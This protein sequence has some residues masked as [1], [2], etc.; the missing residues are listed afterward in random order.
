MIRIDQPAGLVDAGIVPVVI[1]GRRLASEEPSNGVAEILEFFSDEELAVDPN[2]RRAVTTAKTRHA[3]YGHPRRL[4]RLDLPIQFCLEFL[5][6]RDQPGSA[7]EMAGHVRADLD[8][9][10]R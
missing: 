9:N 1:R 6:L 7:P 10:V 4:V 8:F 2:S 3:V 5:Q